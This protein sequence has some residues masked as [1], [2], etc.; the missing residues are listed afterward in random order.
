MLVL[1][2]AIVLRRHLNNLFLVPL[3]GLSLHMLVPLPFGQS[4]LLWSI[5]CA[6]LAFTLMAKGGYLGVERR[7][8]NLVALV[9][10]SLLIV[11]VMARPDPVAIAAGLL[12]PHWPGAGGIVLLMALAAS[13]VGSINHL[14]YPAFV[15]EKGWRDQSVRRR[16]RVDL[17]LSCVG[18]LTIAALIQIAVAA[19]LNGVGAEIRT[20]QDLSGVF[21]TYLGEAGRVVFGIGMWATVSSS[22][23]GSNT[24][25]SL[26]VADVYERFLRRSRVEGSESR[27]A[28]RRRAYVFFLT[29][30][31]V[32]PLYVLFTSWE[33]FWIGIVASAIFF[34]LAPLMMMGLL[35]LTNNRVLMR[36]HVSGWTSKVMIGLAIG[37]SLAL[38]YRSLSD[39]A[40]RL[41]NHLSA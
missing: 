30:F 9:T 24:G 27:D 37:L 19:T 8:K 39:L 4:A 35:A 32:S 38:T 13:T 21:S 7:G 26:I 18:Q 11:A 41:I 14:K 1:A 6:V 15:F 40:A 33:P 28:V 10:G 20:L 31:C 16:Q 2:G 5:L 22:Y 12:A 17:A 23:I 36:E 29:L 3:M 25:Y 34:G